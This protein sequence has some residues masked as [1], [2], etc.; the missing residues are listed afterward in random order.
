MAIKLKDGFALR[1]VGPMYMAVPFGA[2]A[3]Q[4]R[5]MITLSETG[6][7]LWEKIRDGADNVPALVQALRENYEV[8]EEEATQDVNAFIESLRS[9]GVLEA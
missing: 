4:V 8:S 6:Y 2:T 9:Q 3:N 7:L 5:G 1:K